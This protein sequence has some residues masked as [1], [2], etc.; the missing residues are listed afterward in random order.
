LSNHV[1]KLVIRGLRKAFGAQAVLH[2]IDLSVARGSLLALLGP[3]GSGKT[4]LLR[5]VCGF[6]RAD[7]GTIDIDTKRVVG[8]GLHW[9]SEQRHIGYVPQEGALFPH[10][11]VA[12]NIVFGLPRQQRRARHRVDELLELVGLPLAYA[13]RAPQ[14][15]SGGQQ[16]RVALAR[17][18]A[19]S[20]TLVMLDEPFSAL[21][22]ALRIET[23]DAV[24]RALAAAGATAILVTHDQ[25]EAL[26]MGDRV[27]VLLSGKVAQIATPQ[28]LYRSP[29]SPELAAFVG[30][31]VLL[32]GEARG[33]RVTCELGSVRADESSLLAGP[34]TVMIRPEQ[35]RLQRDGGESRDGRS[36]ESVAKGTTWGD[37]ES[38]KTSKAFA[39][40]VAT[41]EKVVFYGHDAS[42]DLRLRHSG[43]AVRIRIAGHM[44]PQ[45]GETVRLAVEGRVQVYPVGT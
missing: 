21:D 34:V 13:D 22:T 10:L 1:D 6:E 7:G 24:S 42:V 2:D 44:S 36:S 14:A 20:P 18:L 5:L 33:D 32:Q 15:L 27:A 11:S 12:D 39:D 19:P 38:T 41:V 17:A 8:E 31:A 3:S 40:C 37:G 9:P 16:Q 35:I 23:R 30:E 45:I 43:L 28:V 25:S 29:I 26:S 4:T